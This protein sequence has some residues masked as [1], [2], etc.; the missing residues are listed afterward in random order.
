VRN[1]SIVSG[2]TKSEEINLRRQ[3]RIEDCAFYV[4]WALAV[5]CDL[6]RKLVL[7]FDLLSEESH[8][9]KSY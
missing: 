4:E 2:F 6:L 8:L 1:F 5:I 7:L 3:H 9:M